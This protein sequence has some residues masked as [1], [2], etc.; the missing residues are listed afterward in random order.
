MK[1]SKC[2]S[3][4]STNPSTPSTRKAQDG[5]VRDPSDSQTPAAGTLRL[6]KEVRDCITPPYVTEY[7]IPFARKRAAGSEPRPSKSGAIKRRT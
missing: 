1:Q 7:V 2:C 3:G 5:R 4:A 6:P